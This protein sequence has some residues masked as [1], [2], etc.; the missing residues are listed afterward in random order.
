MNNSQK[1]IARAQFEQPCIRPEIGELLPDYI[2][3]LLSDSAAEEV[4]E[5][6]LSC[7]QCREDYLRIISIRR[8]AKAKEK[9]ASKNPQESGAE[10]FRIAD[11]K[12]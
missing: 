3:D 9:V 12:K 4:E 6:F 1:K 10:V 11:F 8:L 5:H 7:R 2:V